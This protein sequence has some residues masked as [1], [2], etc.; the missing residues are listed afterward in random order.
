MFSEIQSRDNI[1]LPQAVLFP[2]ERITLNWT[3]QLSVGAG[4][5]NVGNTCYLNSALQCLTYT[6]PFTNYMLS[7]EHSATC[8]FIFHLIRKNIS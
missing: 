2:P 3:Q 6:P 4:L 1:R 5:E 8:N 7:Q